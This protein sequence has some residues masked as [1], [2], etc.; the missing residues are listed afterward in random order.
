[1]AA[2]GQPAISGNVCLSSDVELLAA[3]GQ[4]ASGNVCL[5]G[6]RQAPS[7]LHRVS[8]SP[9]GQGQSAAPSIL[10]SGYK[11]VS[12]LLSRPSSL[13]MPT[14]GVPLIARHPRRRAASCTPTLI[15]P[16]SDSKVRVPLASPQTPSCTPLQTRRWFPPGGHRS[17]CAGTVPP[18]RWSAAGRAE[19]SGA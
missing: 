19:C 17:G 4:P 5:I 16:D 8:A 14:L 7:G 11:A 6:R 10:S 3:R 9:A 12:T 2:R 18:S 1:M 13:R 15:I